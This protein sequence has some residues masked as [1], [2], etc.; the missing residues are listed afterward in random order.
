MSTAAGP[1]G[2]QALALLRSLRADPLTGF[3]SLTNHYGDFV[4]V[5]LPRGG[6]LLLIS[7]P[8]LAAHVLVSNQA[9][10][11]KARTYKPM[12]EVL[13]N[14]LL[15]NE[16]E[17]WARQRRIVQPMFARRHI[18][19]F[20]P[21]MVAAAHT[22]L[23]SWAA[24]PDGALLDVAEEMSALALDVAG[25]A[26]FSADLTGEAG[27]MG[28]AL[29][30]VLDA[31]TKV[32]RSPLFLVAPNYHRWPTPNRLRARAAEA[33]LHGVVDGL[34]SRRR[35]EQRLPGD[36][37]AR[38]LLD[39]LLAARDETTGEPMSEQQVRDELMTFLLAGHE[40]TANALAWTFM[41]LSRNPE[42][43]DRLEAEVD[44]V[45][46]GREA[47]AADADKLTW[48]S[49]VISESMRL[50]PPAWIIEREAIAADELDGEPVP[51]DSVVAPAP[52]LLHRNPDQWPNPEG[53]DPTR[54]LPG[55]GSARHRF[56]YLPFG[57][58]RRQCIGGG[59]AMLESVLL[60]A[61]ITQRYRLDLVPGFREE[62]V[63]TITLRPRR[64]IPMRLHRR[65]AALD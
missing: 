42:A 60:L 54:F 15:T 44:E 63:P 31:F 55:E 33:Q 28:P 27:A 29:A 19:S 45:L 8:E 53:F 41:L 32:V 7:R 2:R 39:M 9:N 4:R 59:F 56:A 11:R 46:A 35:A 22:T 43:R 3:V 62:P 24:R 52:Y 40:T 58:G 36:A 30:T 65:A 47:T 49:A 21:A 16:G 37:G 34:I 14:G 20:A 6:K 10:Y 57:G 64:G 26:L 23:E 18:D 51:A 61:T 25:R 38:D 5:P 17:D 12:T 1:T 13:G 50:Y 48:T